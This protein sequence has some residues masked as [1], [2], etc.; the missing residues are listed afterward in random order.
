RTSIFQS[1]IFNLKSAIQLSL[2]VGHWLGAVDVFV[3]RFAFGGI[4]LLED[5]GRGGDVVPAAVLKIDQG[6]AVVIDGDNAADDALEALQLG[7]VW[8]DHHVLINPFVSQ[9]IDAC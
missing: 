9:L 8:P 7:P 6:L 2:F 3:L 5:L 1:A 4:D